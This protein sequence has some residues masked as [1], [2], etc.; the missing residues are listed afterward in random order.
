MPTGLVDGHDF[1]MI[2]IPV[3]A[4]AH[5]SMLSPAVNGT[6]LSQKTALFLIKICIVNQEKG[7]STFKES[8]S[9]ILC[10]SGRRCHI[11]F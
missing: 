2:S 7:W 10:S 5:H 6:I 9:Y 4:S 1:H 11:I 3:P 8:V